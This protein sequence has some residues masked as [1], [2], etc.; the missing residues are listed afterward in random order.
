MFAVLLF[1]CNLP[2]CAVS[3]APGAAA[4]WP[5]VHYPPLSVYTCP[6]FSAG[7]GQAP[8]IFISF[9]GTVGRKTSIAVICNTG[10]M[11]SAT[12]DWRYGT[13]KICRRGHATIQARNGTFAEIFTGSR[14][15]TMGGYL[16]RLN[17]ADGEQRGDATMPMAYVVLQCVGDDLSPG[18]LPPSEEDPSAPPDPSAI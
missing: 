11:T 7:P 3:G 2:A 14:D 18:P 4:S 13:V 6:L 17:F 1:I 16:S 9:T 15:Q 8:F 10:D 5:T 12:P